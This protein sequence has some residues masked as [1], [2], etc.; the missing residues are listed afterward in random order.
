M[1]GCSF[2]RPLSFTM[3]IATPLYNAIV[4]GKLRLFFGGGGGSVLFHDI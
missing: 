2:E 1:I 4:S 3:Y